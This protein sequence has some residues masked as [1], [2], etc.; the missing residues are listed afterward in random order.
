MSKHNKKILAIDPG[1]RYLGIAFLEGEKLIYHGVRTI[2][3]EKSP[4]EKLKE[5][6]EI[7][8]RLIRDYKPDVWVVQ[9]IVLC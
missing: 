2:A 5:G 3:S 8:L 6:R 1:I 4:N 9:E 7:I